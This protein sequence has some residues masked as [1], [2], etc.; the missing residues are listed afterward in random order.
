MNSKISVF[1]CGSQQNHE[2]DSSGKAIMILRDGRRV[3]STE[4]NFQKYQASG[5]VGV[6]GASVTCSICGKSAIEQAMWM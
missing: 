1:I 3:E 6:M 2:C 4:E 5:E